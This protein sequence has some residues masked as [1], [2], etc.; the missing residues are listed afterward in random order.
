MSG[1]ASGSRGRRR[2]VFVCLSI[3]TVVLVAVTIALAT[4]SPAHCSG[5]SCPSG[6]GA[7]TGGGG[8]SVWPAVTG[9]CA[10]IGAIGTL[11]Q[12]IAAFRKA[13]AVATPAPVPVQAPDQAPKAKDINQWWT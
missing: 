10:V 7:G 1:M 9:A 2:A 3:A 5:L 12:G 4:A 11:L 6:G 8:S 13:P